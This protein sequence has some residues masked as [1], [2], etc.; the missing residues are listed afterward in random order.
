MGCV[1]CGWQCV[2][3]VVCAVCSVCGVRC[4]VC[5]LRCAVC[6]VRSAVCGVQC[7]VCSVRFAVCRVCSMC[8]CARVCA[9]RQKRQK[10]QSGGLSFDHAGRWCNVSIKATNANIRS[11]L[12]VKPSSRDSELDSRRQAFFAPPYG[13]QIEKDIHPSCLWYAS[14]L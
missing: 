14:I 1:V 4:A 11:H 5:G 8:V 9:R 3:C 2:Q 10:R 7:A 6:G 12:F 13:P